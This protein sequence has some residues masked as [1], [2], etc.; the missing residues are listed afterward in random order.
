MALASIQF[1]RL[2]AQ[3]RVAVLSCFSEDISASKAARVAGVNRKTVN[4][5]YS[6]LRSA[7]QA[8]LSSDVDL[9]NI[10]DRNFYSYL[11]RRK[12][13]YYGVSRMNETVFA[14]ESYVRFKKGTSFRK[15][16]ESLD[17]V[18]QLLEL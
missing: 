1:A 2:T 17:G 8:T 18:K 10:N 7:L 13:L 4:Q 5:W 9:S 3:Q 11:H 12:R 14:A 16:L 6:L 15:Y